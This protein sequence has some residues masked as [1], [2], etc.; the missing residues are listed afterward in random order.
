MSQ[1]VLFVCL[2]N[3][4]RS[5]AAEGV[6]KQL[7][8][9]LQLFTHIDSAGTSGYHQGEP[10]HETIRKIAQRRG[11]QLDGQTSR[12]VEVGDFDKFDYIVAMDSS[13]LN[14]LKMI[15]PLQHKAKLL[16]LLEFEPSDLRDVPDP[17]YGGPQG[18]ED[19]F[20][21]I[22]TGMHG[23]FTAVETGLV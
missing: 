10:P 13:N 2:G 23:F 12:Q 1:S 9:Q 8:Q 14:D 22:E 16:T 11:Y 7:N 3:I 20:T 18:F 4:C 15:S 21:I 19:C 5:P 6:A 17:Y